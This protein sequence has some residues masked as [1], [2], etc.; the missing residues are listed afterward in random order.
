MA[1]RF[2]ISEGD[3]RGALIPGITPSQFISIILV[4]I[5]VGMIVYKVL[6]KHTEK[7]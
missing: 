5:G 1:I 4:L 6:K 7:V 2:G 3:D